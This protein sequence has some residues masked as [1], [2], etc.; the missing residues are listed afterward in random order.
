M[1]IEWLIQNNLLDLSSAWQYCCFLNKHARKLHKKIDTGKYY[2]DIQRVQIYLINSCSDTLI[3]ILQFELYECVNL[4][5]YNTAISS[6]KTNKVLCCVLIKR[7]LNNVCGNWL[8]A[9]LSL[10]L[11]TNVCLYKKRSDRH[12]SFTPGM[13]NLFDLLA[14]MC[15]KIWE[16]GRSSSK[17]MQPSG[18]K[19]YAL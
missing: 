10:F 16:R 9:V 4:T 15:S 6:C 18:E 13:V 3:L 2:V 12:W 7:G 8:C 1:V 19:T 17:W 11:H 5:A 14:T